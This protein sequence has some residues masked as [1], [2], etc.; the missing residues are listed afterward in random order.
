MLGLPREG[1]RPYRREIAIGTNEIRRE[2]TFLGERSRGPGRYEG[3][4][5][6]SVE[7][8]PFA[9][10]LGRPAPRYQRPSPRILRSIGATQFTQWSTQSLLQQGESDLLPGP[11]LGDV[12]I[13]IAADRVCKPSARGRAAARFA[14]THKRR[15]FSSVSAST[16]DERPIGA[17]IRNAPSEV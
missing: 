14:R 3:S 1:P 11:Y 17:R 13:G 8:P 12:A 10:R 6:P 9:E 7:R 2:A 4:Q 15:C 5:G 16:I